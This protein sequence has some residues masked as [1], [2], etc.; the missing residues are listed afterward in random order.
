MLHL[1]AGLGGGGS[2]RWLRDVVALSPRDLVHRVVTV[3]P[4]GGADPVFAEDLGRLAAY[5][6]RPLRAPLT[7]VL[8]KLRKG[9]PPRSKALRTLV[10][11]VGAGAALLRVMAEVRHFRPDVVHSH[12]VPDF[13]VGVAV[14]RAF[15]I[16]LVHTVPCL[17]SQLVDTGHQWTP[18]LYAALQSS[19]ACFSTGEGWRELARLHVPPEK[20]LYDLGGVD[21]QKVDAVLACRHNHAADVRRA[22]GIPADCLVAL[23]VGRLHHSKGHMLA[24]DSLPALLELA[25]DLH[26]VVVGEG[27]QRRDLEQRAT[28]LGVQAHTHLVGYHREPLRFYAAADVY[29]R[30]TLFEPENLSFYDAMAMGLPAIGFAI[31]EERDLLVTVGH[32]VQ[33][34]QGDVTAFAHA[35]ARVLQ[36]PDRGR[37][38][39][40]LAAVYARQ[41]LDVRSSVARLSSIYR[42]LSKRHDPVS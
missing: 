27:D 30:S 33:V 3:I 17:F 5:Q 37:S 18:R 13:P 34:P 28:R 26:W 1:I 6:P 42:Q 23:S 2:E 10:R 36:M 19:V 41:N 31:G 15:D 38:L 25:P 20:I 7:V 29:F 22:M 32:G 12:T 16:P 8:G 24:L 40:A 14:S 35:A 21:F 39:G 11:G 4:D 9:W